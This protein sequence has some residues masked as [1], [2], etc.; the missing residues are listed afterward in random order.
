MTN[1]IEDGPIEDEEAEFLKSLLSDYL[2][3]LQTDYNYLTSK[4][5]IIETIESNDYDF[6]EEG[7]IY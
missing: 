3:M 5:Q 7:K 4:E 2:T 6:T 1:G